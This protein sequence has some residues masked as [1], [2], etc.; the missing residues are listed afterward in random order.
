MVAKSY[1]H[2]LT[3]SITL[4]AGIDTVSRCLDRHELLDVLY[5]NEYDS[6]LLKCFMFQNL[7]VQ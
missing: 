5:D 7:F 3:V 1:I 6:N 2:N 4:G